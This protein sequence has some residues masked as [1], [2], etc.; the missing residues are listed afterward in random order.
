MV[1]ETGLGGLP[2]GVRIVLVVISAV[3]LYFIVMGVIPVAIF[4]PNQTMITN[5]A[6]GRYVAVGTLVYLL[7]LVLL[8]RTLFAK[9]PRQ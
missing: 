1:K 2:R 5:P 6:Y 7:L 9:R 3:L 4:G 8:V